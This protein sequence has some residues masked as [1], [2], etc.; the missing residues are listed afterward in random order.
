MKECALYNSTSISQVA[1]YT[2]LATQ[3]LPIFQSPVPKPPYHISSSRPHQLTQLSLAL[4]ERTEP[5]AP[6]RSPS[7]LS[8][9]P[10]TCQRWTLCQAQGWKTECWLLKTLS[11]HRQS[12]L[13]AVWLFWGTPK[14]SL[15][16]SRKQK[17]KFFKVRVKVTWKALTCPHQPPT[18]VLCRRVN[19]LPSWTVPKV[20]P[21]FATSLFSSFI[22]CIEL[23]YSGT[24]SSGGLGA[25]IEV[26]AL[27]HRCRSGP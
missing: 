2:P 8:F 24:T 1:S 16:F 11:L 15:P 23:W 26:W 7:I 4:R 9:L 20:G 19:S 3:V 6:W 10:E 12:G 13:K 21:A 18:G 27:G 5:W 17:E 22:L 25:V 14:Y